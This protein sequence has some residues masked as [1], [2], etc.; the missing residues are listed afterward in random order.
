MKITG[1]TRRNEVNMEIRKEKRNEDPN[2]S[3]E[4]F[5]FVKKLKGS[6]NQVTKC[7]DLSVE[8]F[9]N[10]FITAVDTSDTILT[11]HRKSQQAEQTQSI[12]LRPVTDAEVMQ[13]ISTLKNKKPVGMDCIEVVVL[14]KASQ[15]VSPYLTTAFNKCIYAGV[16]PQ[17]MK[18]TKLILILNA[19]ETNLPSNYRPISI[20]GNLSKL[21]EN[22]IHKKLMNYLEKFGILSENQYGFIKRFCTSSNIAFQTNRSE[23]ELQS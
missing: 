7:G 3:K 12:F 16:F 18:M 1:N 22:V 10:Y 20:L 2:S 15:I 13:H 6:T 5:G 14:K 19:G 8:D 11:H 17:S 21:F 23:L 4:L 9:S